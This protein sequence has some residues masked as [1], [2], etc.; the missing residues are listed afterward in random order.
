MQVNLLPDEFQLQRMLRSRIKTWV[1]MWIVCLLLAG[2]LCV[3]GG[4]QLSHLRQRGQAVQQ[5][6]QPLQ[7]QQQR[8]ERL[9]VELAKLHTQTAAT[10][11]LLPPDHTL[12]LLAVLSQSTA[13]IEG[14]IQTL[15]LTMQSTRLR[16]DAAS[17]A[18]TRRSPASQPTV[19]AASVRLQVTLHGSASSD[20]AVSQFVSRLR[21]YEVFSKVELK[22][23]SET[24]G[25]G[26]GGRAFHLEL[27]H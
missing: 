8:T 9:K 1:T 21:S 10:E 25:S 18:P 7:R 20:Q 3:L 17:T 24:S 12:P 5:H 14:E 19:V 23:S 2:G 27:V 22:S 16:L 11:N 4:W 26:D 15:R 6:I 13:D